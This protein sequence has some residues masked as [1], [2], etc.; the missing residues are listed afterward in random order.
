MI[1]INSNDLLKPIQYIFD[2]KLAV[3]ILNWNG[4]N[5]TIECLDSLYK[6]KESCFEIILVDNG[7][8]D[9]SAQYFKKNYSKLTII[10]NERNLGFAEGNNKGITY[11]LENG[12][13][14]ILLLNNDTTVTPYF[15][16]ELLLFCC[17]N[18]KS[19]IGAKIHLYSNRDLLDH[20]GGVWNLKK[21]DFDLIGY[22]APATFGECDEE[23]NLDYICGCSLLIPAEV[24][25]KIGLL[26]ARFFLYFE[27]SDFC[28]RSKS[29]GYSIKYCDKAHLFHKVSASF[30]GGKPHTSYFYFRNRLLWIEKNLS[31]KDAIIVISLVILPQTLKMLRHYFLKSLELLFLKLINSK[32]IEVKKEKHKRLKASLCGIKD[33]VFRR[34]Y[35]GP[36]WLFTK[37]K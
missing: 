3:I 22:R 2:M 27:E 15:L 16:S 17:E 19:L 26:D 23:L 30:I 9:G 31:L 10:E 28:F 11:A 12:F 37:C 6:S 18:P 34:F 1:L 4:K 14:H 13:S 35:E 25:K 7:S 33:Y 5:D 21:G 20:I 36:Q 8:T 24:I 32:K 29:A